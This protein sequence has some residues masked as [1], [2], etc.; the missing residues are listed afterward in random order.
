MT[1]WIIVAA[2][3]L[4]VTALL[5]L[6][7]L[8]A[9]SEASEA[10]EYDLQVYRDQLKEVERD[11]ARGVIGAEDAERLRTEVSRRILAADAA[12]RGAGDAE[13]QQPRWAG[14]ALAVVMLVALVGG[15]LWIYRDLG[16]PGYGDLPLASRMQQAD[17]LRENRP[18]QAEA[19]QQ[20]P[21]SPEPDVTPEYAQLMQRLRAAVAE[22]PADLQ[23]NILLARNEAALGN[24]RAAY[25]AQERILSIK[26][27]EATAGDFADYAEM[28]IMAA[29]GY[30]SPQAEAAL[31]A[32]LARD[33][34]NP[35]AR[36]YIGLMFQQTGRPDRTFRIWSNLLRESAPNAPWVPPIREQIERVA[37]LAGVDYELPPLETAPMSGLG[38]PTAEDIEAAQGM[39]AEDRMAMIRG[40]VQGLSERLAT[41]GGSAAEWAR[42]IGALGVL[43]ETE[44]AREI[45]AEARRTFA[46]DAAGLA[47]IEAAARQAGI[48]G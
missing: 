44:Q 24:F 42:L 11:L 43:G 15:G 18:V 17:E 5:T 9:R 38:G 14:P 22:R 12:A 36:Y 45:L 19:E 2:L 23:G 30:V 34:S 13:A 21:P 48:K 25:E 20:V 8:R 6:A 39:S 1:F 37:F 46:A 4:G 16:A 41:E 33:E 3:A 32:A 7:A 28:M 31:S 40:M 35:V 27:T 26:G 10:A 47:Q 29:G